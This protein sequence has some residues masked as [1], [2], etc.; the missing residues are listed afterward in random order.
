MTAADLPQLSRDEV[1]RALETLLEM[2]R[3]RFL[4]AFWGTGS[5]EALEARGHRYE[6]VPVQSELDLRTK[7]PDLDELAPRRVYLVPFAELPRDV[8]GLFALERVVRVGKD[9]RLAAILGAREVDPGVARSPLAELL[10]GGRTTLRPGA[11]GE[12]VTERSLVQAWM[13]EH[14]ELPIG[15]D[16]GRDALLAWAASST[17]GRTFSEQYGG[18]EVIRQIEGEIRRA[19]GYAG[20]LAFHAW[21]T[22]QGEPLIE[23]AMLA[24]AGRTLTTGPFVYWLRYQLQALGVDPHDGAL[25]AAEL[26]GALSTALAFL[27]RRTSPAYVRARFDAAD[28]RLVDAEARQQLRELPGERLALHHEAQT[29]ALAKHFE[30]LAPV[31]ASQPEDG[32]AQLRAKLR[33]TVAAFHAWRRHDLC[34]AERVERAQDA[35]RLAIFL[36]AHRRDERLREDPMSPDLARLARWYADQGGYVDRAR[37]AARGPDHDPLGRA[38]QRIVAIA[39]TRRVELDHRFARGLV[40][41]CEAGRPRREVL[42]IEDALAHLAKPFLEASEDRRLLVVLLDG[43]SWSEASEIL[44]ALAQHDDGWGPLYFNAKRSPESELP[45]V[46]AALPTVTDVSRSAFFLG[47]RV[48]S[49]PEHDTQKD[50]ERL[51]ANRAI[52]PFFSGVRAPRLFLRADAQTKAGTVANEVLTEIADPDARLVAVVLNTIDDSLKGNP[53][54]RQRWDLTSIAP[55]RDLL[56]AARRAGRHVL[57]ASDHGHVKSA[58]MQTVEGLTKGEGRRW[59]ALVRGRT[60]VGSHEVAISGSAVWVPKGADGVVL[61]A[62]DTARYGSS[63]ASGEHGGATLAEVVTPCLLVGWDDPSHVAEDL[64][65]QPR[66]APAWYRLHVDEESSLRPDRPRRKEPRQLAL[67]ARPSERPPYATPEGAHPS[68]A[69]PQPPPT[70]ILPTDEADAPAIESGK[71]ARSALFK[72]QIADPKDRQEVLRALAILKARGGRMPSDVFAQEMRYLPHRAA[73]VVAALGE[74]LA[75]DGMQPLRFERSSGSVLLDVT[76]FQALYGEEP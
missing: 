67:T 2:N 21:R 24:D 55:L 48:E 49:G 33:E 45:V 1:L 26:A 9:Q 4:F 34:A 57:F 66:Y 28:R 35:L 75:L 25:A 38:I 42:G 11:A 60:A 44:D 50:P 51:R 74:K 69:P 29:D 40:E 32:G 46:L 31:L 62:D 36:E 12:L 20:R 6:V 30:A 13:G 70:P 53:S 59:R 71:L 10:L 3:K 18:S 68:P 15:A 56:S 17:M 43:M 14:W 72:Q 65:L 61:L 47:K 54:Q 22:G 23:L 64:R 8:V 7:L 41:W 5:E 63:P 37:L 76:L 73:S 39:S 16:F 19:A 27:S 58:G 52:A